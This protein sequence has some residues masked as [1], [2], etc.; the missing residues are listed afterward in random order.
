MCVTKLKSQVTITYIFLKYENF[1]DIEWLLFEF[2]W[3]YLQVTNSSHSSKLDIGQFIKLR[4]YSTTNN[5]VL[6]QCSWK[7]MNVRGSNRRP[8]QDF[9]ICQSVKGK[10]ERCTN[11]LF[12]CSKLKSSHASWINLWWTISELF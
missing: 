11:F 8:F 3:L 4:R 6:S 5:V 10:H 9:K 2:T 12:D 7:G 1:L